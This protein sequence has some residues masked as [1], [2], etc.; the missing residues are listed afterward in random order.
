MNPREARLEAAPSDADPGRF[1]DQDLGG[2]PCSELAPRSADLSQRVLAA[3]VD[4]KAQDAR[5]CLQ[6]AAQLRP[7]AKLP[8][9]VPFSS[10]VRRT[11]LNARG[12][13]ARANEGVKTLL[14]A[15]FARQA[16]IVP[17]P[18]HVARCR[19]QLSGPFAP[20]QLAAWAEA[21]ALEELV[22]TAP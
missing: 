11:R 22:L 8:T 21:L 20:D 16:G 2:L 19:K 10:F 3:S 18:E 6:L 15:D 9:S 5:A 13:A 7:S 1:G 17:E 14:L 12:T 4:L